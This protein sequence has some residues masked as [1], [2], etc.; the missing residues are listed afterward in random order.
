M[1]G[2]ADVKVNLPYLMR[3]T[4][5]HGNERIY[6]R[7]SGK[8][9]RLKAKPGTPEFFSEY[10]QALN[11]YTETGVRPQI[12][13]GCFR[14]LCVGYFASPEFTKLARLTK[15]RRRKILDSVCEK[16]GDKPCA[17][18]RPKDVRKLR[19]AK[20]DVPESAN[21][22][23]KAIRP[24]YD[25]AIEAD[26]FGIDENPARGVKYLTRETDG[27]LPWTMEE[28]ERFERRWPTGTK[29]RLA[30]SLMRWLGVRRSDAVALG[31]Q[32]Y[33][34]N[35]F[36]FTMQKTG[37]T[38]SVPCSSQLLA[39]LP[40]GGGHLTYLVTEYG[41]PF[42]EAGFGMRFGEWCKG[43]GVEK[44]AHGLRKTRAIELAE[45]G[46]TVNELMAYFG[47]ETPAEAI[48]YTK[49]AQQKV[50]AR[51]AARRKVRHRK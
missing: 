11:K 36:T 35:W 5:R 20:Q 13:S 8:K 34:R 49:M 47:W 44:R 1:W 14:A 41:R 51:G 7:K 29:P 22:I 16:H 24:M 50:L 31:R 21:S 42:S 43:A 48:R 40:T 27:F 4:D 33:K 23:I 38:I 32:H 37:K 12:K 45:N 30:Y 18:M 25:W 9:V 17:M 39:E 28:C 46:A 26:E 6:L 15:Q 10:E 3:D 19:D 2:T